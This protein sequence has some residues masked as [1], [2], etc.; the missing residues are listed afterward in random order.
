MTIANKIALN[1]GR[2]EVILFKTKQK[3]CNTNLRL[4]LCIKRVNRTKYVRY[5]GIKIDENVNWKLM[6]Y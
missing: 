1:V 6:Q 3:L 4:K 5:A 2:T